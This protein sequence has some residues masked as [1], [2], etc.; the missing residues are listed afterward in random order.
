VG[1]VRKNI[2]GI[3]AV[4]LLMAAC[5]GLW[6]YTGRFV[7]KPEKPPVVV[8]QEPARGNVLYSDI[9]AAEINPAVAMKEEP[10]CVQ[11]AP[12]EAG[13]PEKEVVSVSQTEPQQPAV[14][15]PSQE[16]YGRCV[17]V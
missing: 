17:D 11:S 8:Q 16:E 3:M 14:E 1:R 5:Y 15:T 9:L 6:D 2:A 4:I 12:A 7:E 13:P 10:T